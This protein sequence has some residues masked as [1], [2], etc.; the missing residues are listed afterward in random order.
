LCRN[1]ELDEDDSDDLP[2]LTP[3]RGKGHDQLSEAIATARAQLPNVVKVLHRE[4][5]R[6]NRQ[7][8]SVVAACNALIALACRDV[9]TGVPD[10]PVDVE[11]TS[12]RLV[13]SAAAVRD[14][15]TARMDL[16]REQKQHGEYDA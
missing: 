13:R 10:E 3:S 16:E 7:T 1:V 5:Q 2:P 15:L 4:A 9:E 14:E 6:P 11:V 12:D 8:Q